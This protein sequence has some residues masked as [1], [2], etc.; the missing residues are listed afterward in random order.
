LEKLVVFKGFYQPDFGQL[1]VGKRPVW[2]PFV[3][4]GP[5]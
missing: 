5:V 4:L 2:G 1:V 3:V